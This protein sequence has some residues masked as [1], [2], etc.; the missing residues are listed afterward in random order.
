MSRRPMKRKSPP[1]LDTKNK[2]PQDSVENGCL[3]DGSFDEQPLKNG[4]RNSVGPC[5]NRRK[6]REKA[7][8]WN[9]ITREQFIAAVN[10]FGIDRKQLDNETWRLNDLTRSD[11]S[12]WGR[13]ISHLNLDHTENVRHS[14]YVFWRRH[15]EKLAIGQS[16]CEMHSNE[17][18]S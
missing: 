18:D 5:V 7:S 13:L 4:G 10:H 2:C 6:E 9:R 17:E 3:D 14:L 1:T 12:V 15:R 8:V 11:N 16:D